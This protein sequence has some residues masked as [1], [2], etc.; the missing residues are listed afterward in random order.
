MPGLKITDEDRTKIDLK[1][2]CI[3]CN[4][5]LCKPMQ[6]HCG[7]ALDVFCLPGHIAKV[8]LPTA[9]AGLEI[10]FPKFPIMVIGS[11]DFPFFFRLKPCFPPI[12]SN[13]LPISDR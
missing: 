2:I 6:T 11:H 13:F 7:H 12:V 3:I 9:P 10:T 5:L 1:F 4:L 8:S